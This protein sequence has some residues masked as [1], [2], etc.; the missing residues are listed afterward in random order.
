MATQERAI[1]LTAG[2]PSPWG[3]LLLS[4]T[5]EF[6]GRALGRLARGGA[7]RPILFPRLALELL[8]VFFYQAAQPLPDFR[9][10]LALGGG[11]Q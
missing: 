6:S 5:L 8:F 9:V 7:G 4:G 1:S 10:M 11:R 3:C 2:G